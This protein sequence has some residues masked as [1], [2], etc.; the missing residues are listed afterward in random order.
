MNQ[1][2]SWVGAF[3]MIAAA[4]GRFIPGMAFH[5]YLGS[6]KGVLRWHEKSAAKAAAH[7]ER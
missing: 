2:L 7:K 4:A 5:V 1:F 6:S 3:F